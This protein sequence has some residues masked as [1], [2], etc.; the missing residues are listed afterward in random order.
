VAA[1]I[2]LKRMKSSTLAAQWISPEDGRP[3]NA[4]EFAKPN[5]TR[6]AQEARMLFAPPREG[7]WVLRLDAVE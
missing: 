4:W 1:G 7:D 6:G 2:S 3:V 5:W